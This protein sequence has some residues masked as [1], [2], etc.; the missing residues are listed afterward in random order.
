MQERRFVRR[1]I[2]DKDV[3]E[4]ALLGYRAR[5]EEIMLK[6]AD[7]ER[8]LGKRSK[9]EVASSARTM[10]AVDAGKPKR[11]LSAAGIRAIRAGVK[12]RWAAFHEKA[13]AVPAKKSPGKPKREM[14][15]AAKE[16]LAANLALARAAR[17]SKRAAQR[18]A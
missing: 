8:Q 13:N 10:T 14:S 7:I 12:K 1:Q 9:G 18:A 6:M 11:T 15:A 17:A 16:K 3:L 5:R 4:M 2:D